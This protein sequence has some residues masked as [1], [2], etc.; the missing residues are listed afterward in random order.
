MGKA[1]G[2]VAAAAME[3]AEEEGAKVS[4]QTRPRRLRWHMHP[5]SLLPALPGPMP[6]RF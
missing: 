2:E 1:A 3:E 4:R 6:E 5:A